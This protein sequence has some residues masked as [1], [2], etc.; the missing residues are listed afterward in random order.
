MKQ[1]EKSGEAAPV[2]Y[3]HIPINKIDFSPIN[4][5]RFFNPEGIEEFAEQLKNSEDGILQEITVRP[6]GKRYELIIGERRLRA[7]VLAGLETIPAKVRPM[8][9]NKV[10]RSQLVENLQRE[11]PHPLHEAQAILYLVQEEGHTLTEAAQ[12]LGKS[13]A[14]VHN[15]VKLAELIEPLQEVYFFGKMTTADAVLLGTLANDSQEDFFKQHCEGWKDNKHFRLNAIGYYVS[16]YQQ[17]LTRAPFNIRDKKLVPEAGACTNCPFNSATLKTLFPELAK[18]ANCS[19]KTCFHSKC[20]ASAER[21]IRAVVD[22]HNPEAVILGRNVDEAST[23]LIDS[24]PEFNGLSR[25]AFDDIRIFTEPQKPE[26]EDAYVYDVNK[27]KKVFSREHYTEAVLK[28]KALLKQYN[29][30]LEAEGTLRAVLLQRSEIIPVYCNPSMRSQADQDRVVVTA[31]QV[32]EAIKEGTATIEI[33]QAEIDRM[34]G[35]ED[36]FKV[37]DR[38]KIQEQ[39]YDQYVQDMKNAKLKTTLT[40]ADT[41]AMRYLLYD[42]LGYSKYDIDKLLFPKGHKDNNDLYLKLAD[43]TPQQMA[44]LIR[45]VLVKNG[46]SKVPT[47]MYGLCLYKMAEADGTNVAAIEAAQLEKT[48]VR[49]ERYKERVADM[50]KTI[51]KIKGRKAA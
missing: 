20:L 35:R 9:D 22:A 26:R 46:S 50:Q 28:Y 34:K 15:R 8:E 42:S 49:E 36:R 3:M 21:K 29:E 23:T 41:V 11:N 31:K 10:R 2:Q 25:H 33:V 32:K 38:V 39:L 37:L 16:Q 13:P 5:R 30:H 45:A 43:L 4:Y 12:V 40:K 7:A 1:Q 14:Y 17:D 6:A 44:M 51:K 24:L 18:A 19:N 47:S 48:N 27:E